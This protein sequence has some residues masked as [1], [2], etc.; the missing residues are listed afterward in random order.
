[1]HSDIRQM[2]MRIRSMGLNIKQ[3]RQEAKPDFKIRFEHMINRSDMMPNQYTLMGM[4]SIPIAPWSSKMYKSDIKAMEF[5]IDAMTQE[6]QAMLNEMTGM[7]RSMESELRTMQKQLD[8]YESKILPALAKNMK[9]SMLSY[10][11]NKLELPM[12]I[13][14]WETVNMA[15]M[16]YL[17]QLQKFYKMIAEYEKSIEK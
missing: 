8:N 7:S 1:M 6:R 9:V 4:V 16:N 12:V 11:E 13:D 17:D 2:D 10:Q 15:Q 3:M 14:S 5:E